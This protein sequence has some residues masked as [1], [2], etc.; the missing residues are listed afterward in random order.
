M[1][2]EQKEPLSVWEVLGEEYWRGCDP[3]RDPEHCGDS[4][5]AGALKEYREKRKLWQDAEKPEEGQA[6]R[7][8]RR[9][10]W[11]SGRP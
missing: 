8:T 2:P 6:K 1:S 10:S 11:L 4:E 9:P 3:P 5:Y 7:P